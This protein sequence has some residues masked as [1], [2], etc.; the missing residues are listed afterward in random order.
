GGRNRIADAASC[1]CEIV[2]RAQIFQPEVGQC[3]LQAVLAE[4]LVEVVEIDDLERLVL[5]GTAEYGL[6]ALAGERV[7]L[8]LQALRAHA[9]QHALHRCADR[10][11]GVPGSAK[12]RGKLR[13]L[14][15]THAP[16]QAAAADDD[17]PVDLLE[18]YRRRKTGR[19]QRALRILPDRAD[20]GAGGGAIAGA[21][22]R[23]AP[24]VLRAPDHRVRGL[25]D[26][27]A[28]EHVVRLP[29]LREAEHAVALRPQRGAD[30]EEVGDAQAV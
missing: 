4:A 25:L 16:H 28:Q 14:R 2:P 22:R 17:Q 18:G 21:L 9:L 5:P 1:A 13:P 23:D 29:E 19:F 20:D 8:P 26:F 12:V 24:A 7:D 27:R 3:L 10:G 6:G 11:D 30:G 15:V